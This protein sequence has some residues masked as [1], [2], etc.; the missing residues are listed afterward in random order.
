MIRG[1][2][3]QLTEILPSIAKLHRLRGMLRGSEYDGEDV[4]NEVN[5]YN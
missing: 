1:T 2:A 3:S 4:D 5:A